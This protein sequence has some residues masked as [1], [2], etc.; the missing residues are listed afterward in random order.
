[1]KN[2]PMQRLSPKVIMSWSRKISSVALV[3][4]AVCHLVEHQLPHTQRGATENLGK[5]RELCRRDN[6]KCETVK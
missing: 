2:A 3:A 6:E 5:N 4:V 1:M